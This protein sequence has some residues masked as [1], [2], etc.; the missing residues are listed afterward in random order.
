MAITYKVLGSDGNQYGPVAHPE[1][2][3]WIREGRVTPATRILRS[4][5]P[6]WQPAVGLAELRLQTAPTTPVSREAPIPAAAPARSREAAAPEGIEELAKLE[7]QVK[8]GASWF[9]WI[10]GLSVINSVVA[11]SGSQ[12]GFIMGLGVTQIV[13]TIGKTLGGAGVPVAIILDIIV[14]G[15]FVLFGVF[16][17]QRHPWAFIVGMVLYGLDGLLFLLGGD[18]LGLGFHGFA[19]FC[20]FAGFS[21]LKKLQQAPGA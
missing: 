8:S 3:N 14:A 12:W 15:V 13:D 1:I 21:A 17:R 16:A 9:F 11:L 20:I 10:A 2:Q 5:Q 6:D 7:N 19:L 18:L 4:D